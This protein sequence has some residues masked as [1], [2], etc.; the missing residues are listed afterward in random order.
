MKYKSI[1]MK[2]YLN[3]F[4]FYKI[5]IIFKCKLIIYFLNLLKFLKKLNTLGIK[6]YSNIYFLLFSLIVD[7]DLI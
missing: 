1:T 2:F 7:F 4:Y 5:F 6:I 3:I